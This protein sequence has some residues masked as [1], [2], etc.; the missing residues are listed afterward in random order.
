MTMEKLV[1]VGGGGHCRS[2]IDVIEAE[3]KYEIAGI[4][5]R[6]SKIGEK[7]L[8]Y[9]I[10]ACD[11]DLPELSLEYKNFFI[12]LGQRKISDMRVK[13]YN[14]L[15]D[16]EV[17]LVTIISP[18]SNVSGHSTIGNGS[19]IM[20][21]VLI[22]AGSIV[23]NNCIINNKALIEHDS[24]IGDHCCISTAAV[25]NG[26]VRVGEKSYLGSASTSVQ[27][28]DIAPETIIGAGAVV[29]KNITQAGIY[30]GIPAKAI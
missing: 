29:T 21:Q 1:L 4:V 5:D 17:K 24:V 20:H 14:I 11:D 7:V 6:P 23:G 8:G 10:F 25:V 16:L 28:I 27:N 3:G 18:Y 19:I 26:G 9:D 2:C 22:V 13:M 15:I 12:T 30:V